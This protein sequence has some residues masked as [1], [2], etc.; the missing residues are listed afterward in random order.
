MDPS[1]VHGPDPL[2]VLEFDS[3]MLTCTFTGNPAPFITWE[4]EGMDSLSNETKS[5]LTINETSA[6]NSNLYT[7]R[8]NII[9][10]GQ[11]MICIS[12][13]V[14]KVT[15]NFTLI[16][17]SYDKDRGRYRCVGNNTQEG[18]IV[19]TIASTYAEIM[20]TRKIIA[21]STRMVFSRRVS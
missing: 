5:R 2:T 7:V 13:H 21:I 20:V 18:G 4:K 3:V 10:N 12:L 19:R 17:V 14:S 9:A 1:V 15:S 6:M 8:Y 16:A 11:I